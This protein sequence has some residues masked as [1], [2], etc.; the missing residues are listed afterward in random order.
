[1][2]GVDLVITPARVALGAPGE[3]SESVSGRDPCGIDIA[4]RQAQFSNLQLQLRLET[5]DRHIDAALGQ[6]CEVGCRR[7]WR[8]RIWWYPPFAS[9]A[10]FL[11]PRPRRFV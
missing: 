6:P 7:V 2:A 8:C 4:A 1:M 11:H 5:F 3:R 9:P 10:E